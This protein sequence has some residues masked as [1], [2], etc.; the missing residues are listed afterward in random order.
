ML[1]YRAG[2]NKNTKLLNIKL[3]NNMKSLESER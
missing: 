1:K 2:I 3:G